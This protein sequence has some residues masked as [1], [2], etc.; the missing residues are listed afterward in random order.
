MP[1]LPTPRQLASLYNRLEDVGCLLRLAALSPSHFA[2]LGPVL[3]GDL[4][5]DDRDGLSRAG[6]IAVLLC[7]WG[8]T[9][10]VRVARG[11]SVVA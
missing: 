2:S 11:R 8:K 3:V 1:C 9:K 10:E 5:G 7:A 4:R 6:P